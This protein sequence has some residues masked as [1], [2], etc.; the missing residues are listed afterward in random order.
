MFNSPPVSSIPPLSSPTD[1]TMQL[2]L[3][4]LPVSPGGLC[5]QQL[6]AE[7]NNHAVTPQ[8]QK[9][10]TP[11]VTIPSFHSEASSWRSGLQHRLHF[12]K[13]EDFNLAF[14]CCISPAHVNNR[15]SS[16]FDGPVMTEVTSSCVG[17]ICLKEEL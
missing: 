2:V 7:W 17:L 9:G 12:H 1:A 14:S 5:L 13:V 15:R 4:Q 6:A 11:S 10:P 16:S 3:H 8:E